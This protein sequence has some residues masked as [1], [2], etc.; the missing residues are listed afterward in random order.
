[1]YTVSTRAGML[2]EDKCRWRETE[3]LVR[4]RSL[5]SFPYLIFGH[6]AYLTYVHSMNLFALLRLTDKVICT[7]L[8]EMN[9]FILFNMH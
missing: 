1:M 3:L 4:Y 8:H 6:S 7:T 5:S 9:I 2:E